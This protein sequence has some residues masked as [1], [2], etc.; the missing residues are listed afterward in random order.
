MRIEDW[1]SWV[2]WSTESFFLNWKLLGRVSFYFTAISVAFCIKSFVNQ[3]R[4]FFTT[5]LRTHEVS[6]VFSL[7]NASFKEPSTGDQAENNTKCF[8]LNQHH[9][10]RETNLYFCTKNISDTWL[11]SKFCWL[12]VEILA[13]GQIPARWISLGL[14]QWI[15][16][17]NEIFGL[18][19]FSPN[20]DFSF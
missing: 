8:A 12:R 1:D 13:F 3:F 19:K 15:Q 4:L 14:G 2:S 9:R 16:C 20:C 7:E 11:V 6:F 18:G 10:I 17:G 5:F